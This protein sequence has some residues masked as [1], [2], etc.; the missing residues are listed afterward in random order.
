MKNRAILFYEMYKAGAEIDSGGR[1]TMQIDRSTAAEFQAAR[2][3]TTAPGVTVTPEPCEAGHVG[4]R[5]GRGDCLLC[6]QAQ[7]VDGG[8]HGEIEALMLG[9]PDL[10]LTRAE[11]RVYGFPVYRTG[12]RCKVG[13]EWRYTSTASCVEC[14]RARSRR[15]R[16][17]GTATPGSRTRRR[18][19]RKVPTPSRRSKQPR[20]R[21]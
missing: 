11:A 5:I 9:A 18:S 16:E 3:L 20:R 2:A 14:L 1:V 10:R 4:V 12:G 7:A 6:L 15:L 8:R 17:A 21:A 19:D 13:H